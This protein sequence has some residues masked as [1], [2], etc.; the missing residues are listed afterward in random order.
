MSHDVKLLDVL[1]NA[2]SHETMPRYQRLPVPHRMLLSVLLGTTLSPTFKP[3]CILSLTVGGTC[4]LH[5]VFHQK[6]GIVLELF[7]H[8]GRRLISCAK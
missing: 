3:F 8:L 7:T 5:G 4:S 1:S 2:M 6:V